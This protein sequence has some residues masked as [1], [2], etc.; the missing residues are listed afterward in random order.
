ML[1]RVGFNPS[2]QERMS[3]GCSRCVEGKK[4]VEKL[5]EHG[6]NE[7]SAIKY[8]DEAAPVGPLHDSRM[9]SI[10]YYLM[11]SDKSIITALAARINRKYK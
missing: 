3:F 8:M 1:R 4:F 9:Q 7:T 10:R 2:A 6:A 11:H 5:I